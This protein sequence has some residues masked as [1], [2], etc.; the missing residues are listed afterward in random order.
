VQDHAYRHQHRRWWQLNSKEAAENADS[1][2][3]IVF[4]LS[5]PTRSGGGG[6]RDAIEKQDW[7]QA[8]RR[9]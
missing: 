5:A 4:Q 8:R 2:A 6:W 7:W 3:Q 9:Q 1:Y